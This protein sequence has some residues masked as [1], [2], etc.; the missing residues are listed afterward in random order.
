VDAPLH[1]AYAANLRDQRRAEIDSDLW[2]FQHDDAA[3]T[4]L[5][6]A[7]HLM[8]RVLAG[9][10]D[11]L[12]WSLDQAAVAGALTQRSV[13]LSGRAA[14]AALF[15]CTSWVIQADASRTPP[16]VGTAHTAGFNQAIEA[17]TMTR[18]L[19]RLTAGIMATV[20]VSMHLAAQSPPVPSDGPV[21]EVAS[22]K[23]H[24]TGR[25]GPTRSQAQPGGRF[26][27]ENIAVRLLIGQAY[28][29]PSY[30]LV[31]GPSWI[32][33]ESFDIDVKANGELSARGALRPLDGALRGLLADR[34]KLV[35]HMETRRLPIYSLVM[36]RA[37][38]RL[39]PNLTRSSITDCTAVLSAVPA[40]PG[41]GGPP[42]PPAPGGKA[43]PC[44]VM[45][46]NGTFSAD[47]RSLSQLAA[48][49]SAMVD[50]RVV[51][52]TGLTGLFN[53]HLTWTPDQMPQQLNPNAP[54]IDPNG[55]SLFTAVQ[56]QLGL[57]LE[58]TTGPVDV[59]V[60]DSVERPTPD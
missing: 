7:A 23:P 54:P 35:V 51:D 34:F 8:A 59:L 55:P 24:P 38:G 58:S 13:A 39:G 57:K 10:P 37:D 49:V 42:P 36:A 26:V 17:T 48:I 60:I 40:A 31:G 44:G 25:T 53:A 45:A 30:R 27:A 29:V 20:A 2:E 3:N 6:A 18:T 56:D 22:I 21:F 5:G 12:G 19:P 14:G 16:A 41:G 15:I 43:P 28:Q 4:G 32:E 50:R 47:S 52:Q 1:L 9:V 11:D 33:S 46:G